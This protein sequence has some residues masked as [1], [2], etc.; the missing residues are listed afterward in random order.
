[1]TC[2]AR[3]MPRQEIWRLKPEGCQFF[4]P[5]LQD[6]QNGAS[7]T[8]QSGTFHNFPKDRRS[9]RRTR[10]SRAE[11]PVRAG[12][13]RSSSFCSLSR[14]CIQQRATGRHG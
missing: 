10:L 6:P 2:G 1:M 9:V 13:D 14:C 8:A 7:A 3:F 11:P 5:K 4:M 12:R